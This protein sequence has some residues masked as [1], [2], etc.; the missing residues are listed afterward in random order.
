MSG[1]GVSGGESGGGIEVGAAVPDVS[2]A[3]VRPDGSVEEV[4][5]PALFAEKPVLLCF[6]TGDFTPDCVREWCSL[7]D[8]GW[9]ESAEEVQV[10]GVSKSGTGMHRRFIDRLNLGFPLYSDPDLELARAFG[11]DYRAFG[12]VRRSK[13]SCFLVDEEGTVRY[14][15]V[16]RHWLDPTRAAPPIGELYDVVRE[17]FG[18]TGGDRFGF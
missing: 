4:P 16:G 5:L 7:R 12:L 17:E 6:Y 8:F 15:W 1:R 3:L 11:V 13:R 10:V 9:F 18:A 2:G 14:R